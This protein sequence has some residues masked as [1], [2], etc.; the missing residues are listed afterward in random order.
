MY[1][2]V[3]CLRASW[4]RSH[5]PT[6][7][8]PAA[9]TRYVTGKSKLL[10]QLGPEPQEPHEPPQQPPPPTCSVPK[11]TAEDG[12]PPATAKLEPTTLAFIAPPPRHISPLPRSPP[13]SI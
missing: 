7:I 9:L 8:W 2:G 5:P 4:T 13:L 6:S 11:S 1:R 10:R 3:P 12:S